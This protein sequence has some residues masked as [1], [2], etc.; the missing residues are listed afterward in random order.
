MN[1][2]SRDQWPSSTATRLLLVL[3]GSRRTRM[4][5]WVATAPQTTT[6]ERTTGAVGQE[7]TAPPA[8]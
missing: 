2:N 5:Y 8:P 4:T 1:T 7:G 3:R 6:T